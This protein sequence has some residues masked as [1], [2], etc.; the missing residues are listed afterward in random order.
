MRTTRV[1]RSLGSREL[2]LLALGSLTGGES[3]CRAPTQITVEVVGEVPYREGMSVAVQLAERGA[4]ESAPP[5]VITKSAW[6]LGDSL[7]TVVVGPG[8]RA[9]REVDVRIALGIDRD[10]TTC[11]PKN[12]RGCLIYRRRV[13]FVEGE[14]VA[15]R[16]VLRSACVGVYCDAETSCRADKTCGAI[17]SDD[18]PGKPVASENGTL[19]LSSLDPYAK[20]VVADRPRHYYRFDEP[21]GSTVAKDTMGRA[22][23]TYSPTV[24]LGATGALESAMGTA[25]YFDGVSASVEVPAVDDFPGAMTLEAW[26][27]SD[28]PSDVTP[29]L[30]ERID[31]TANA[32]LFGYR[33]SAPESSVAFDLFRGGTPFRYAQKI[34]LSD[35]FNAT[36]LVAIAQGGKTKIY[37]NGKL[38]R[39]DTFVDDP[40]PPLVS[41]LR[42]GGA[43][44]GHFRGTIDELALYDYPLPPE[45]IEAHFAADKAK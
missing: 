41:P 30:L 5:R 33:L 17:D 29:V 9:S 18:T 10:P 40:P 27:R 2:A 31:R 12:S 36:H 23:G 11:T 32:S 15:V 13:S 34:P 21:L 39:E 14:P 24:R 45:A 25:A 22:D 8:D 26:V 44:A 7:G 6:K 42:V 35:G 37:V 28:S 38:L 3:A 1:R 20:L 19:D 43:T 4:A 16:A